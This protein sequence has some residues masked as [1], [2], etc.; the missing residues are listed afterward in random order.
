MRTVDSLLL[1][2]TKKLLLMFLAFLLT[3]SLFSQPKNKIIESSLHGSVNKKLRQSKYSYKIISS[4]NH[5]WGYDIYFGK[6]I[7]IHQPNKPGMP[8]NEG[9]ATKKQAE[10]VAQLVVS[11]IKKGEM[12]PTVS[13]EEMKK[14]RAIN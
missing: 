13:E 7:L 2:C 9:F 1:G 4:A 11:K 12:P 14:L 6:T 5:T 8:G 3:T 10:K